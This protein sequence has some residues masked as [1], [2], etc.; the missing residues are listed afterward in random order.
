MTART[1]VSFTHEEVKN[2]FEDS[3]KHIIDAKH[4]NN[5][6][7]NETKS[8]DTYKMEIVWKNVVLFVTMHVLAL[9]GFYL[10]Y[11]GYCKVGTFLFHY[12]YGIYGGLSVTAGAH[13]L[14]AHRTYS[15]T[16]PLRI[17]FMIGHTIAIQNDLYIWTRDHRVHHKF[18]D[19]NADPHNSTR[20]FFFSHIGWLMVKK[21]PDVIEKG[22]LIDLS[23]LMQDPVVRF[24]RKYYIPLVLL[25]SVALPVFVTCYF[26]EQSL[27]TSILAVNTRLLI[28]LHITWLV[29]S[30]AHMWGMKPYDK[31][32]NPTDHK[33]IAY[34]TMGEGWHNYHHVFPWDYKA[35]ELGDYKYNL[36]TFILDLAGKLGLAYDFKTASEVLIKK[37]ALRTGDQSHWSTLNKDGKSVQETGKHGHHREGQIWGWGDKDMEED[38]VIE[39]KKSC[40]HKA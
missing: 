15:A 7:V 17:F 10:L 30:G 31:Y 29:N 18:T 25:L 4:N 37:R 27:S 6:A 19:Q 14:W 9:Y 35:A 28:G 38:E 5:N 26:F 11:R 12:I 1:L 3:A 40:R 32:I 24:Q 36:S 34:M 8:N 23:D 33:T 16:L 2:K 21:H 13:R 39:V 22:K 20:G